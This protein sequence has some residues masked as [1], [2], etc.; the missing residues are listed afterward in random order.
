[1]A[2]LRA[3][4]QNHPQKVGMCPGVTLQ[5]ISQNLGFQNNSP[6]QPPLTSKL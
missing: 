5:L 4:T 6:E 2:T 3:W 1:M